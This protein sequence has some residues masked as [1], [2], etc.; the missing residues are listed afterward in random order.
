MAFVAAYPLWSLTMIALNVVVI[1]AITAHGAEL[2]NSR[3]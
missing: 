3:S 1:Y 2:K